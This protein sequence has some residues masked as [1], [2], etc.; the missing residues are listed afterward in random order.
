MYSYISFYQGII[1]GMYSAEFSPLY[2]AG[3]E[4]CLK[5]AQNGNCGTLNKRRIPE[6]INTNREPGFDRNGIFGVVSIGAWAVVENKDRPK[7][8]VYLV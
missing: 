5:T 6:V 7:V 4:N 8:T 3:R 1:Q 2:N